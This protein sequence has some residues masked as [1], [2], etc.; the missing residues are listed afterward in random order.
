[1]SHATS[2]SFNCNTKVPAYLKGMNHIPIHI[3]LVLQKGNEVWTLSQNLCCL[4]SSQ[5]V[6]LQGDREKAKTSRTMRKSDPQHNPP[7]FWV[8]SVVVQHVDTCNKLQM[9]PFK[10]S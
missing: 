4:L 1:M 3:V 5:A 10:L 8:S 9:A 2:K 7:P 6:F